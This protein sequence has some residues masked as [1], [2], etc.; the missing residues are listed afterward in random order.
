MNYILLTEVGMC[1]P[2]LRTAHRAPVRTANIR[3]A[4]RGAQKLPGAR[5]V[6]GAQAKLRAPRTAH[7]PLS[8]R[9]FKLLFSDCCLA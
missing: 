6:R 9:Q 2:I 7:R 8:G 3:C 5:K 4:V 1:A